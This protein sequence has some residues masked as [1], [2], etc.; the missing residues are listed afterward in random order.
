MRTTRGGL[1]PDRAG[2]LTPPVSK[3][4]LR[5]TGRQRPD[6][7]QR[8]DPGQSWQPE[9]EQSRQPE[10]GPRPATRAQTM[11]SDQNS[12]HAWQPV[13][14]TTPG[15]RPRTNSRRP[16]TQAMPGDRPR[17]NPGGQNRTGPT[18]PKPLAEIRFA[19]SPK[20]PP[21]PRPPRGIATHLKRI[22]IRRRLALPDR[23]TVDNSSADGAQPTVRR[24]STS[25]SRATLALASMPAA[26]IS[27]VGMPNIAQ[28]YGRSTDRA[29]RPARH[30]QG[31]PREVVQAVERSRV[32]PS[33]PGEFPEVRRIVMR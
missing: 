15:N 26:D 29:A 14:R 24:P 4:T 16:E 13:P 18:K 19:P 17:A 21:K 10:P 9:L 1:Y 3:P 32:R 6:Q 33:P 30:C 22:A 31:R 7:S 11:S 8:P 28:A 12:N 27:S 20:L 5:R 25:T 2:R 23:A